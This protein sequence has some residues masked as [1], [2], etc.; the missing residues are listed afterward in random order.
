MPRSVTEIEQRDSDWDWY[1]V[2]AAGHIGHFTTAGQVPLPAS[3][4]ADF[5][6]AKTL[7]AFFD[8]LTPNTTFVVSGDLEEKCGIWESVAKRDRYLASFGNAACRG[9]FSHDISTSGSEYFRV[10]SPYEPLHI[11]LV[12]VEVRILLDRTHASIEFIY[13]H[14]LTAAETFNW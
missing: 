7:I 8:G 9:L 5:D 11:D 1:A 2:D 10:A 14:D 13:S 6:A 12:P 3:V 4:A